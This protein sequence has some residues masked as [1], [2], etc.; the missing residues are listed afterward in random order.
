[1]QRERLEGAGWVVARLAFGRCGRAVHQVEFLAWFKA[2]G[3]ARSDTDLCAGAWVAANAR[4]ARL[5]REY[6]EPAQL[7]PVAGNQRLLHCVEDCVHCVLG[8]R[9][10]KASSLNDSLDKVLF[11]HPG[12]P[13]CGKMFAPRT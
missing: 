6:A 4:L 13:L 12:S 7:D 5:D 3:L 8:L 1:M 10:W 11:D 9:T 2:N